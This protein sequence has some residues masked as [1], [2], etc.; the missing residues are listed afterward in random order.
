MFPTR[1]L[2]RISVSCLL[3]TLATALSRAERPNVILFIAD[4]VSWN[5]YGCYGNAAARTPHIDR[6]AR[7]GLRFD[8]AYLTELESR[9]NDQAQSE[10]HQRNLFDTDFALGIHNENS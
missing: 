2:F 7:G 4:D 6:L 8:Q 1:R 9:R 3:L 10:D 5:D